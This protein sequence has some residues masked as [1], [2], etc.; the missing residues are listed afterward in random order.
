MDFKEFIEN[1]KIPMEDDGFAM[2]KNLWTWELDWILTGKIGMLR[3]TWIQSD[4]QKKEKKGM[5]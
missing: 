3:D 2:E 1:W 5:P 4:Q